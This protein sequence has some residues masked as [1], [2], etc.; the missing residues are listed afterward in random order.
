MKCLIRMYHDQGRDVIF[1]ENAAAP[2]RRRHAAIEAV[3]LPLEHGE[4][5]PAFFKVCVDILLYSTRTIFWD[6]LAKNILG[7]NLGSISFRGR[8]MVAAQENN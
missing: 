3:P 5:A 2:H 7:E 4:V 6:L 8:R 1:Y